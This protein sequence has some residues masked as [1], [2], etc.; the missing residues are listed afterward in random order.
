MFDIAVERMGVPRET[1]ASLGDR[2]DTDIEG[3]QRAG[4]RSILVLTGVTS[5]EALAQAAIRPDFVFEN[6]DALR[7]A[8]RHDSWAG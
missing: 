8:W 6:L 5:R 3:G 2:L 4:L 7:E 1:T